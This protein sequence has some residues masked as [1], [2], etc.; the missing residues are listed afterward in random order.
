[1]FEEV[2]KYLIISLDNRHSAMILIV[3]VI[4]TLWW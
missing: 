4:C 1:M 2:D 3:I